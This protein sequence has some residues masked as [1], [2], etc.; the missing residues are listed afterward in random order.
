M[1]DHPTLGRPIDVPVG[2]LHTAD[3]LRAIGV[4]ELERTTCPFDPGYDPFTF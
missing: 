2:T 4:P 1:L 3:Y